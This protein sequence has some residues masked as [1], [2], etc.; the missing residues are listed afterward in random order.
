[1]NNIQYIQN[2]E[3]FY[4]F[5]VLLVLVFLFGNMEKRLEQKNPS[6]KIN[7]C[8]RVLIWISSLMGFMIIQLIFIAL[9]IPNKYGEI[10]LPFAFMVSYLLAFFI[11]YNYEK[12]FYK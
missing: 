1:M 4:I 5:M 6:I 2:E 3:T 10:Y 8:S 7:G 9:L 12:R 11:L